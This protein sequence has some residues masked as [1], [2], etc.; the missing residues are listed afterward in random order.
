MKQRWNLKE[1]SIW[2]SQKVTPEFPSPTQ[3]YRHQLLKEN[4]ELRP[5]ILEKLKA[6]VW[7]AHEDAR[8]YRQGKS[9]DFRIP[10]KPSSVP[11]NPVGW[12]PELLPLKTQKEYFG[13]IFAGLVIE[14]FAPFGIE[15]WIV[16]A[17]FFR[18]HDTAYHRLEQISVTGEE[19]KEVPGIIGNDC[20]AFQL[21][22]DG[23]IKRSIV[24]EAKCTAEDDYN[25]RVRAHRQVSGLRQIP[26]SIWQVIEILRDRGY[27]NDMRNALQTLGTQGANRNYERCDLIVYV[28]GQLPKNR[29]TWIDPNKPLSDYAGKRRLEAVEAY[30][31]GVCED[32]D[33]NLLDEL[34]Q[35]VHRKMQVEEM[36][37]I[38]AQES[39]QISDQVKELI[40]ELLEERAETFP[41]RYA[42][43]YSQHK[44]LRAGQQGLVSWFPNEASDRLEEAIQLLE[45]AFIAR[46][47]GQD[48]WQ[49]GMQRAGAILE[50]LAHPELNT[51]SL[52]LR[53]LS[54]ATYQLAG[55]PACALGLLKQEPTDKAESRILRASL[56]ADFPE[57]LRRLTEYWATTVP[58]TGQALAK[59]PEA[60]LENFAEWVVSE[61]TQALGIFCAEMR[62]G[63]EERLSQAID[64]I[65]RVSKMMLHGRNIYSWLLSKLCAEVVTVYAQS[66]FR[67][68]LPAIA[69]DLNY[70]G[71]KALENYLRLRYQQK[72]ALAWP[73]QISGIERL[74][75]EDSFALCTPTG[76]GK[77]TVAEIAIL[78]SLFRKQVI[79]EDEWIPPET[80]AP[81]A[82][83]LTPT[84]ALSAEVESTLS[85]TLMNLGSK[86]VVV[87]GPV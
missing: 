38:E 59:P 18:F 70:F 67:N 71:E 33:R 62:W 30:I 77:T 37:D 7:R 32:P 75:R 6:L 13:E 76:S 60:D 80:P 4:F 26:E 73:S 66:S 87:T 49:K 22:T 25:L 54:A 34:V 50:W 2:L 65:L 20:L 64:K 35:E 19:A 39:V 14:N 41:P 16:P 43:L 56:K 45:S 81:L 69:S 72:K 1:L 21:D 17:F 63:D 15:D 68:H 27:G 28:H 47:V 11:N 12:Q 24:C 40:Q 82:I 46:E 78:Q 85:R 29:P 23:Y 86:E 36:E 79:D 55:Y 5:Q 58:P 84:R 83:Y 8:L 52:P 61:T 31:K 42:K 44:R 9:A 3:P 53:L 74:K 10:G 48:H 51:S 57:L